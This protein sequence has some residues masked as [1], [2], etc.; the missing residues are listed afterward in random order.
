[1]SLNLI[2]GARNGAK[3]KRDDNDFYATDPQAV[4]IFLETLKKDKVILNKHIWECACGQGHMAEVFK[5]Y[6]Y[7]VIASDLINRGY[8]HKLDFLNA[9]ACL[10]VDI[11]TNPPFKLAED[12][13]YKSMQILNEKSKLGLFLKIQFLETKKRK[14]LFEK[15]PPKFIYIYSARQQCA[16]NGNFKKYKKGGKTFAYIWII[17]EKG[18]IGETITRWI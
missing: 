11:F 9:E 7:S 13:V 16:L 10:P 18:F 1:M 5:E 17:W 14:K 8:G 4:K 12:F 2:M 15:Y 3:T 6:G